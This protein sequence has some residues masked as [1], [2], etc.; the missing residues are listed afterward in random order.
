MVQQELTL[1]GAA[2]CSQ[3]VFHQQLIRKKNDF[4]DGGFLHV[5]G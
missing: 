2:I 4:V 5:D 3:G 1:V